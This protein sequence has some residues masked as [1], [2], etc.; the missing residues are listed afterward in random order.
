MDDLARIW[1]II[2]QFGGGFV[3]CAIGLWA[4]IQSNYLDLKNSEDK[5]LVFIIIGG[6]VFLLVLASAFTFWL[7][8]I[9]A[10]AAQ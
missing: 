7:P 1:P 6:F 8:N 3:L 5:R 9:P 4:G 10:E 2:V